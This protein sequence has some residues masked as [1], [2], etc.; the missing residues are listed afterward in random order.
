MVRKRGVARKSFAR[1]RVRRV[2]KYN[3]HVTPLRFKKYLP[4]MAELLAP[5]LAVEVGCETPTMELL[6]TLGVPL[7]EYPYYLGFMKRMIVLYRNFTSETLASEK[8]SLITE[9]VLRGKDRDVLEEVQEVAAG[10]AEAIFEMDLWTRDFYKI[11]QFEAIDI[12]DWLTSGSG[13][14]TITVGAVVLSTGFIINSESEMEYG[15]VYSPLTLTWD[16][17]RRLR[18]AVWFN[19]WTNQTIYIIQGDRPTALPDPDQ[20]NIGF[21][22]VNNEIFGCV[23]NGVI[24][25][26]TPVLRILV[27][28]A[29]VILE[30]RFTP[31]QKC[32][33]YIDGVEAA[34]L[35]TGLPSGN[36]G[37]LSLARAYITNS[38]AEDKSIA[39][40]IWE[41]YQKR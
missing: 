36:G 14:Y 5:K 40:T 33:F 6:D 16:K 21:K 32:V 41:F 4:R 25:T 13:S 17:E 2:K 23:C 26:L 29:T 7:A 39:Y 10:C 24:E 31:N 11:I 37:A 35:T 34:T 30:A 9:Y 18:V 15:L 12:F 3:S 19:S 28:G 22:I 20:Q 8:E 27:G 38:A 1:R